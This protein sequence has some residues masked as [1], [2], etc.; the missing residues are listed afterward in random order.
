MYDNQY[1]EI[2]ISNRS[3]VVW[4]AKMRKRAEV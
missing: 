2:I 1:V 4:L 3:D